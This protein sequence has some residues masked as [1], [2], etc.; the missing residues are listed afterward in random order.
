MGVLLWWSS[1]GLKL[2][3]E[4]GSFGSKAVWVGTQFDVNSGVNKIEVRL[5]EKKNVELLEAVSNLMDSPRW[6][7]EAFRCAQTCRQG[8]LGGKFSAPVETVRKAIVGEYV[9][10]FFWRQG[11]LGVQ[12]ASMASTDMVKDVSWAPSSVGAALVSVGQIVGRCSVGS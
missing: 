1:L 9:Q 7:G 2:A 3:C 11:R 5:P 12:A 8:E 4:K 10:E 6:H